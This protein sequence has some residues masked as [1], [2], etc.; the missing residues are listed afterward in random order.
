VPRP[1]GF[2]LPEQDALD[3]EL[4]RLIDAAAGESTNGRPLFAKPRVTEVTY[5]K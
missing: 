2:E 1:A 4:P 5:R 3:Q